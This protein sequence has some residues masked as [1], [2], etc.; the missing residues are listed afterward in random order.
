[1]RWLAR[2][3]WTWWLCCALAGCGGEREARW[4]ELSGAAPGLLESGTTLRI[5]GHG[6]PVGERCEVRFDG[7]TQRPGTTSVAVNARLSGRALTEDAVE[8]VIDDAAIATLGARGSFEGEIEVAF[9]VHGGEGAITGAL[10]ERLDVSQAEGRDAARDQALRERAQ[11]VLEFAGIV[12]ADEESTLNGLVLAEARPNS[13][14]EALGLQHGDVIVEIAGVRVHSLRD[15]APAPGAQNVKLLVRRPGQGRMLALNLSLHGLYAL[16]L[17]AELGRISVL[18]A[19]LLTCVLLFSPLPSLAPWLLRSLARLR[20]AEPSQLGLW[21]GQ[22]HARR[23]SFARALRDAALPCLCSAGGVLLVW[24]EPVGFLAVRS[25]SLYLG[26][27]ALSIALTLMS[28]GGTLRERAVTASGIA[29]RML[30]M[31]VLIACACA[32]SGTRAFD[33]MV[34]WQGG[35]P[36]RWALLQ[37]PALL[38]AF[39]LYVVFASRLG[40][41]TLALEAPGRAARLLIAE[42][43]LTNVVLCALGVAIFAGGW[44]S[45]PELDV[46]GIDRRLIGALLFVAKTWGF[47]WTLTLARRAGWGERMRAPSVALACVVTIGLTA[48]SIWLEPSYAIELAIGRALGG[49]LLI[50]AFVTVLRA[51]RISARARAAAFPESAASVSTD[52]ASPA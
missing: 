1:M 5:A 41:A 15:L 23:K 33:G 40:A 22:V 46:E 2:L 26:F 7:R 49:S 16:D 44:Q 51:L 38:V 12:A 42:R 13:P 27:A 21:G 34:E 17:N 4:L 32:L 6:F 20:S 31:G 39:P 47:A 48:L 14:A 10:H 19:W 30:V 37:K 11:R 43:V 18:L 28:D 9:R 24:L 3:A 35:W 25:I 8:V 45:P 36:V 29:G 52:P 50:T